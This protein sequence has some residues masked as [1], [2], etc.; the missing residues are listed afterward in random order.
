MS[1]SLNAISLLKELRD[2]T[3]ITAQRKRID[4]FLSQHTQPAGDVVERVA[5]A[6]W[7]VEWKEGDIVT[8]DQFLEEAKA[9]I[10]AMGDRYNTGIKQVSDIPMGDAQLASREICDDKDAFEAWF[11]PSRNLHEIASDY[12]IAFESWKAARQHK[13][14]LKVDIEAATTKLMENAEEYSAPVNKFRARRF[15]QICAK[16]WGLS[17]AE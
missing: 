11:M 3:P 1:D 10:A 2:T 14:V 12:A 15:A 13:P 6:I 8:P 16:T 5:K 9:A 17:H 4:A 7:G